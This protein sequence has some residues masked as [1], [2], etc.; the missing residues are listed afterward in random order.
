MLQD[1]LQL[2]NQFKGFQYFQINKEIIVFQRIQSKN[3]G[4]VYIPEN[5]YV[6]S[7]KIYA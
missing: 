4:F 3:F 7:V 1:I 5:F 2:E 6:T